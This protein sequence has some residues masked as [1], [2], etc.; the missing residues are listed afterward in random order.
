MADTW[1]I[2]GKEYVNC[3]CNVGCPCQFNSP[4]THGFCEAA[5]GIVIDEGHFNDIRLNGFR[6]VYLIHWPGEIAKGQGRRQLIIDERA[7]A[8]QRQAIE[9]IVSGQST[10]PG[11]TH[12]YVFD[13]TV[14]ERLETLFK[15]IDMEI[16][17]NAR[18]ARITVKGLV[19]LHGDP[20]IDPFSKQE[21][22]RGIHLPTG[23]E[24]TYAEVAS[25]RSNVTA[26]ITLDLKDT[27]AQFCELHMN[28]DGV[29][30]EK[31]LV[32]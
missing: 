4:T 8:K 17:I 23:F 25:G 22:R 26:G 28:Q 16:D 13:S 2:K 15:P 7:D 6:V 30:R 24:Y 1:M 5:A 14:S 18:R 29:I 27:H 21:T 20:L 9:K 31:Q 12:F 11:A 3:N 19:E 32:R 10:K